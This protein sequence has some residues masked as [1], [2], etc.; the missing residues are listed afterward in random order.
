MKVEEVR[1]GLNPVCT[2]SP[3]CVELASVVEIV[4][5]LHYGRV[6]L[7]KL[8]ISELILLRFPLSLM[9]V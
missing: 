3:C 1:Q 7:F 9:P 6:N 8:E 2:V 4:S 5:E